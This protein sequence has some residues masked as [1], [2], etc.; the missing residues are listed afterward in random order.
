MAGRFSFQMAR[1]VEIKAPLVDAVRAREIAR[2]LS[3]G[4]PE[5][6]DQHDVFYATPAG[7]IKLRIFADGSGELIEYQRPDLAGIRTSSYRLVPTP[8]AR[9]LRDI[10][11]KLGA[12]VAGEVRKRRLLY[13]VGQTRVHIDRVEGLGDFI[14]FED[15]LRDGQ[16]ESEG[17]EIARELM[18]AFGLERARFV[19]ALR[20]EGR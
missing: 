8:D 20:A 12:N 3:G 6:I 14:E 1:N 7:R 11:K 10:L 17:D 19:M 4:D 9:G 13:M 16:E 18:A 5:T 2:H 15:V